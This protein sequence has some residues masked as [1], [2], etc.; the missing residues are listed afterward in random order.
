MYLKQQS[1]LWPAHEINLSSDRTQFPNLSPRLQQLYM[2]LLAFFA[3][4]DGLVCRNV[5]R[6]MSECNSFAESAFFSA[7][8]YI[9]VVHAEAYGLAITSVLKDKEREQKVFEAVE[10]CPA[11]K[12]KADYLL[13]Y[14]ESDLPKGERFLAA[15]CSEGIFF[16]TLFAI[17]FYFRSKN[18]MN[19][20]VLL[21]EQVAKDETLHRDFYCQAIKAVLRSSISDQKA[22]EIVREAVEV[23]IKHIEYILR[24]P[25]EGEVEDEL[26]KLTVENLSNYARSLGNEIL[27]L[28][29]FDLVAYSKVDYSLPWM[30]DIGMSRKTNFYEDKV[31]SYRNTV[32][33]DEECDL[34]NLEENDF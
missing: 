34:V 17:I 1:Q 6:F 21:N 33:D 29:G 24:E 4:G 8:I 30:R 16:V 31:V 25:I 2:D 10:K 11:V 23:E 15:A 3:P 22:L 14:I 18:K 13:K 5:L 20:F 9:E 12:N 32:R 27:R 19:G 7:Q 28:S 26:L